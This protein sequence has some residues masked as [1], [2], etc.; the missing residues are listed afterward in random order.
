MHGRAACLWHSLPC[1]Y[2]ITHG[3]PALCSCCT[4][5]GTL[6]VMLCTQRGQPGSQEPPPSQ[7]AGHGR[8][9]AYGSEAPCVHNHQ[10]SRCP[11][12]FCCQAATGCAVDRLCLTSQQHAGL[13]CPLHARLPCNPQPVAPASDAAST[14]CCSDSTG[15]C[16]AHHAAVLPCQCHPTPWSASTPCTVYRCAAAL[17]WSVRQRPLRPGHCQ[18]RLP[19]GVPL[20]P[21]CGCAT[22]SIYQQHPSLPFAPACLRRARHSTACCCL[23][24]QA[25]RQAQQHRYG[26]LAA[27][28]TCS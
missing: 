3:H 23:V 11:A 16:S 14:L 10:P 21:A 22:E 17:Q 25:G 18:L 6:P 8:A 13:I 26:A 5:W 27:L 9:W 1:A 28:R 19:H 20:L 12:P 15:A 2:L 7:L 24:D 4:A